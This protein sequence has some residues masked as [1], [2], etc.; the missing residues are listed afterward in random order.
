[1]S[2]IIWKTVFWIIVA[3]GL[4]FLILAVTTIAL[5]P[6]DI[7]IHDRYVLVTP[8]LSM[9]VSCA[10]FAVALTVWKLHLGAK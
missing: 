1:M 9:L 6:F 8:I 4:L 5:R 10:L 7:Y 3:G 2:H